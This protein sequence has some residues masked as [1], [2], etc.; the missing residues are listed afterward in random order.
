MSDWNTEVT[1]TVGKDGK[2]NFTGF[3]G[4]YDVTIGN[5]HM[6]FTLVKGT[7]DYTLSR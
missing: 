6:A 7:N 3:Y 5:Q 2:V 4:D 1:A